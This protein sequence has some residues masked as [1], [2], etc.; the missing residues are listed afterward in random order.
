MDNEIEEGCMKFKA[1]VSV[2]ILSP[3]TLRGSTEFLDAVQTFTDLLPRLTPERWGWWEPLEREFDAEHL[4]RLVPEKGLCETV[5]WQRKKQPKAEGAFSVRWSSKS[6]R[7]HDTHSNISLTAELRQVEQEAIVGYLKNASMRSAADFALVDTLA[8]SYRDFAI[9]SG[10]APYGER[11]MVVTHLLRHWLPDVFWGTVFGPPYVRLLGKERLL[12][13]PAYIVEELAPEMVYVQLSERIV[14]VVEDN[15]GLRTRRELFKE[16]FD[17]NVFFRSGQG[18][19][20]LQRGPVGDVFTVPT[21]EL[22]A[23]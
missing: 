1:P 6:S 10:S 2:N 20:R 19:D 13:A 18:Y 12:S 16:H 5:Y 3:L 21:F 17:S 14:D 4:D 9:E 8:G 15:A 11:F 7:V 22:S 23:E